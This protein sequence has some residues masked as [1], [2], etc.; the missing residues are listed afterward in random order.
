MS[1]VDFLYRRAIGRLLLKTFQPLGVYRLIAWYLR[2]G[3]SKGSIPRFIEKNGIDMSE[4]EGREFRSFSDFFARKKDSFSFDS[5]VN[6]L[7]S[8]SDSLVSIY[9]IS[10]E[11]IIPMKGSHYRLIDLVPDSELVETFKGGLCLVYRLR[12]SDYHRFCAFDDYELVKTHYIPG[13]LHS[14]Q[15]IA[16]ETVPVFRLNRRW[17]SVLETAHFGKAI[18]IEVG[19]MSVGG[20]AFAKE[21]GK[22]QR[23]DEM[24]NF[25][26]AGS[27][28]VVLLNGSINERLELLEKFYP[29][30]GGECEVSVSIGERVA[31]L[32]N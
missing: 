18:Q 12:A 17:W 23:G 14:V 22:F 6:A 13:Q 26:L 4:F 15:P 27:T 8:P 16:C 21:N 3:A 5:D 31:R 24:G 32:K 10:D 9:S 30:I 28:I 2:S 11:L 19:A 7:I 29:A 20:V 1:V 25:E